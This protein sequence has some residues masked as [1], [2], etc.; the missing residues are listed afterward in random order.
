M[1]CPKQKRPTGNKKE[2]R[3]RGAND[4]IRLR[5]RNHSSSLSVV[6]GCFFDEAGLRSPLH[7]DASEIHFMYP[8]KFR[9]TIKKQDQ[10]K[11][12][13]ARCWAGKQTVFCKTQTARH[14]FYEKVD[15]NFTLFIYFVKADI[16]HLVGIQPQ[17]HKVRFT[18]FLAALGMTLTVNLGHHPRLKR[19]RAKRIQHIAYNIFTIY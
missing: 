17:A 3:N 6:Y 2:R 4:S 8:C 13:I 12:K 18:R 7:T 1:P 10:Q 5:G 11:P 14:N 15:V 16:L 9:A 19:N